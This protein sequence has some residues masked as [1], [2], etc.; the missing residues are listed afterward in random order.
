MSAVDTAYLRR[1]PAETLP[2]PGTTAGLV[3]W[4]PA[5]PVLLGRQHR[6]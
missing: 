4:A 5:Q 2:P 3:G 1:E 6:S